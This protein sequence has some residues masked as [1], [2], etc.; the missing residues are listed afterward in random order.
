M[1]D[2]MSA[3]KKNIGDKKYQ[4]GFDKIDWKAKPKEK[5]EHEQDELSKIV[6]NF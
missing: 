3:Y 5:K 2:G 4:D 6:L 1:V